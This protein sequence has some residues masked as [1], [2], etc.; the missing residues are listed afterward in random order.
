MSD[1]FTCK[2]RIPSFSFISK[3]LIFY[4][5]PEKKYNLIKLYLIRELFMEKYIELDFV[6]LREK[7]S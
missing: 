2:I 6:I 3:L 5:P 4:E 1:H 7:A